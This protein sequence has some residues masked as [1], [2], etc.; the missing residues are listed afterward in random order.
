MS[1]EDLYASDYRLRSYI[2]NCLQSKFSIF[3][4]AFISDA[5]KNLDLQI[6]LCFRIGFGVVKN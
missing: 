3:K 6:A 2:F 4:R 1:I 5:Y